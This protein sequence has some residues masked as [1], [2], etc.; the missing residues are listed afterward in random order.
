MTVKVIRREAVFIP[1]KQL[2]TKVV[3]HIKEKLSFRFYQEKACKTCDNLPE[4]PND[5]CYNGCAAYQG[6]YDLA[7]SVKVNAKKYLKIPVGSSPQI[8]SYINAKDIDTKLID[9]SP[10]TKIKKIK[11]TGT[12]KPEQEVAVDAI[13]SKKRGVLKAPPRSGKTVMATAA[14]CRLGKKTLILASQRD[15]LMGF[16]ET[17]IGSKTQS[18]LTDLKPERIKL[19]KTFDDF[20]STD[21]CL[22][23]I[24][25]FYSDKGQSIL[26]KIRDLFEVIVIDEVHT[27]AADKY[28]K[29]ISKLNFRYGFGLSGTPG[30]KDG[31]F[32]LVENILGDVIHEVIVTG[33]RPRLHI[34]KTKY[35]KDYKG[36]VPWARIVS[37]LENDDKRLKL[38][39]T[40]AIEDAKQGHLVMI[41]FAQVKPITKLIKIIND[42]LGKRMAYPFTGALKKSVRDETIQRA[43]EYKI[44]ILVGTLKIMST[45]I[46]IP[47]AS[48][49]YE[50]T[51]S[52]NIH[53]AEQRMRRVLTPWENKPEAG[54]RYFIDDMNVRRNCMRNEYFQVA[55]PKIKLIVA[56]NDKQTMNDY[57]SNKKNAKFEL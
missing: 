2:P 26:K 33:V 40:K 38:I 53:N 34:T 35:E 49:L 39:A 22:A 51:V 12:L 56:E 21:I 7:S 5:I 6:G 4:R 13:I 3:T 55:L 14:I 54:I 8:L 9:K 45:G 31:K 43:R 1:I 28:V 25:T 24:Q 48:M 30:R 47:R 10:E 36:N 17:F 57:F 44:K 23:T 20:N 50:V 37:S 41:P 46:N 18:P 11:F 15:W 27:S 32:V 29:I 19:C 16:Q 52:S 42:K